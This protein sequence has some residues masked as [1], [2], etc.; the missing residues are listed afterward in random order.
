VSSERKGK[1]S[2]RLSR[3]N[4]VIPPLNKGD[5]L[6]SALPVVT[7]VKEVPEKRADLSDEDDDAKPKGPPPLNPA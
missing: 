2:D 7:E 3:R 6:L 5:N 1:A 4:T